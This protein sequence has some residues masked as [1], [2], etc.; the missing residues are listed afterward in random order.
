M[1]NQYVTPAIYK[2]WSAGFMIA[3]LLTLVLGVIFLNPIAGSHGG[4]LNSTRFWAVLLQNSLFWLLLVNTSTFFIVITTLAW[5]GW[6]TAFR[7]VSEAVSSMVPIIGG[8]TLVIILSIVLGH[9]SDIYPWLD[10]EMVAHDDIL[11]GKTGFLNP[12][13]YTVAS[14]VCVFLWAFVGKKLRDLSLESD[15]MGTMDF[16]TGQSWMKRN[17]FWASIF[18]VLFGLT[19]GSVM[20]WLWI[21]SIE[22]H[23]FSTMF[24]WYT[25]G[26][27]FVSGVALL[28]LFVI[29]FKNQGQLEFVTQEHL[30][31]LGKFMFAFS[32]FWTYLWFDQFMLIW[33]GNIPEETIYFKSRL[34]GTYEGLF[35]LNLILNFVCPILIF[36]KKATKRNYTIV[37]FMCILIIFGHWIDF[38]LMV[39]PGTVK[40]N[41]H[42]S[43]FEIGIPLGF[44]GIIMWGVGKFASRVPMTP[45][46]NPFL[47]ESI[48]HHT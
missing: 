29:Y 15:K 16:Q 5:G 17:L 48:V 45:V 20:P 43:W 26:S 33:Y 30:Q 46:N 44:V 22:P 32:I 42:I 1:N 2:K 24:S 8:L 18:I 38:Y 27:T 36:M 23:W 39:M 40:N 10:K 4:N 9:R 47:K 35:Y 31:D 28:T 12:T 6:Q 11:K 19:V 7:R 14:I 21:M 37:T 34:Q 13:V 41:P 25:F 3:G